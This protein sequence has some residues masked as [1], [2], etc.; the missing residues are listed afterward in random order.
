[1]NVHTEAPTPSNYEQVKATFKDSVYLLN[2]AHSELTT[3]YLIGTANPWPP[4]KVPSSENA[5]TEIIEAHEQGN[6]THAEEV[7][8]HLKKGGLAHFIKTGIE[9]DQNL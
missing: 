7:V 2:S 5:F 3:T 1:M 8:A 9:L 6:H 4:M